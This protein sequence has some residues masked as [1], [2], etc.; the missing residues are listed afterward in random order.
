MSPET[1]AA[2]HIALLSIRDSG[3]VYA[4]IGI[5]SNIAPN[6]FDEYCTTDFELLLAIEIKSWIHSQFKQWPKLGNNNYGIP[7]PGYYTDRD[8]WN[9]PLRLELLN[10]LIER[11]ET[12]AT[13]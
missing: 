10:W 4:D 6:L 3:P 7:I 2:I 12:G 13:E 11:I 8:K 5:C 1:L 9:N